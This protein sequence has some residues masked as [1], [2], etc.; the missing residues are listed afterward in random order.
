[1][2]YKGEKYFLVGSTFEK[3]KKK[4][5]GPTYA[6]CLVL[7]SNKQILNMPLSYFVSLE[8]GF[9]VPIVA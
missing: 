8:C 7:F 5:V 4:M 2:W 3:K 6:N 9:C 1:M